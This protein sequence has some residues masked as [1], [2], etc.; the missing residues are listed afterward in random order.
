MILEVLRPFSGSDRLTRWGKLFTMLDAFFILDTDLDHFRAKKIAETAEGVRAV[1]GNFDIT[2]DDQPLDFST[3]ARIDAGIDAAEC[4]VVLIGQNTA[5]DPGVIY[6]ISRAVHEVGI[7]VIGVRIDKLGDEHR[8]QGIAGEDPFARS[9]LSGRSLLQIETYDPPYSSSVF[10][11]SHIR[12]TLRDWVALA[13]NESVRRNA[14]V[15]RSN[16][17]SAS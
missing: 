14:R 8:L 4:L 5:S 17:R 1:P 3:K 10:A 16:R 9:G 11:R 7:P 13:I 2:F 12:Y 6:A 15:R